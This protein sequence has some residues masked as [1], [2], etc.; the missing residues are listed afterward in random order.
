MSEETERR[1]GEETRAL[2]MRVYSL[3]WKS[4]IG[5]EFPNE[6]LFAS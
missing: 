4:R 2:S 5:W 6:S 1:E 3:R